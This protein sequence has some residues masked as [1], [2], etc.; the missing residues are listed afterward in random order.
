ML[1]H[2]QILEAAGQALYGEGW[3]TPLAAALPNRHG[4]ST[5]PRTIRRWLAGAQPVPPAAL[6]RIG[7]LLDAHA[8]DCRALAAVAKQA[9]A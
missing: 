5:N 2:P 4:D 6:A 7:L 8:G 1:T 9:A 3:Q